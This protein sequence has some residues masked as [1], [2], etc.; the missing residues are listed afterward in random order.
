MDAK[1]GTLVF[2]LKYINGKLH[3]CLGMKKRGFAEGMWNG[4]GGKANPEETEIQAARRELKE[5]SGVSVDENLLEPSG[6]IQYTEPRGNWSVHL[7]VVSDYNGPEPQEMEE[8]KPQ[9]WPVDHLPWEHMWENDKQWLPQLL[10]GK[11]ISGKVVNGE[12]GACVSAAFSF[13]EKNEMGEV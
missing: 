4:Y 7:F 1:R 3:V 2:L 11:V 8:M 13:R 5:E 6:V 12:N 10:E 9:Y